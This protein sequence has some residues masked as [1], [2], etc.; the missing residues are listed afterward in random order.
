MDFENRYKRFSSYSKLHG[1]I[2]GFGLYIYKQPMLVINF[3]NY[4]SFADSQNVAW[5]G[6]LV[7]IA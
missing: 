6:K 4:C 7:P 1:K 5:H 2:A 3:N